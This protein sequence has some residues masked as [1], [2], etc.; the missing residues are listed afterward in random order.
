MKVHLQ[1]KKFLCFGVPD[2]IYLTRV[3]KL[4]WQELAPN[5]P[6]DP[7]MNAS[8]KMSL[9]YSLFFNCCFAWGGE[10]DLSGYHYI[11]ILVEVSLISSFSNTRYNCSVLIHRTC[12]LWLLGSVTQGA[13]LFMYSHQSNWYFWV[14]DRNRYLFHCSLSSHVIASLFHAY[15]KNQSTRVEK[16]SSFFTLSTHLRF[17]HGWSF[18][19]RFDIRKGTSK[20]PFTGNPYFHISYEN[21]KCC[22]ISRYRLSH[23]LLN[24]DRRD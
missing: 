6:V 20:A 19:W 8:D 2:M 4:T 17:S 12:T 11:D 21:S 3:K 24:C 1:L 7:T 13:L 22:R 5:P 14:C 15:G 18:D 23:P 10:I 9:V 16:P